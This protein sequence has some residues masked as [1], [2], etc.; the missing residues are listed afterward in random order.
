MNFFTLSLPLTNIR[1][2]LMWEMQSVIFAQ[3]LISQT[4]RAN[5]HSVS[6]GKV[7]HGAQARCK[8]APQVGAIPCARLGPFE[9]TV[10]ARQAYFS[11]IALFSARRPSH[12]LL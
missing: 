2:G 1:Y 3:I 10:H 4:F 6:D 7:L 9:C 8:S 12:L 11:S 5:G